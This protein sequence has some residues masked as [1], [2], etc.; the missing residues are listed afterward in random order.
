MSLTGR[1][2]LTTIDTSGK[3]AAVTLDFLDGLQ[4]QN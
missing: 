3:M 1:R 2:G 4:S